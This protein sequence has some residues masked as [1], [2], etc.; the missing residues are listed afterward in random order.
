VIRV[1]CAECPPEAYFIVG[2]N[3]GDKLGSQGSQD[4]DSV[5]PPSSDPLQVGGVKPQFGELWASSA[6]EWG[7]ENGQL[8]INRSKKDNF[9]L[10]PAVIKSITYTL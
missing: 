6:V 2:C 4:V 10:F 7:S 1:V 5:P 3:C 9:F 8:S